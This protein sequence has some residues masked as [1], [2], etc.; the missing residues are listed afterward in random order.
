M[1]KKA[2]AA[3]HSVHLRNML[4]SEKRTHREELDDES[5]A[6]LEL[7]PDITYIEGHLINFTIRKNTAHTLA[8]LVAEEENSVSPDPI[9]MIVHVH[10]HVDTGIKPV[11]MYMYMYVCI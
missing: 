3:M 2:C 4:G 8:K 10:V 6:F 9:H 5:D 1:D 7:F 11:Y